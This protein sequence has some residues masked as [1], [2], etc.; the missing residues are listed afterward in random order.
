MTTRL[1]EPTIKPSG[2]PTYCS[3][4]GG[5]DPNKK[6]VDFDAAHDSGWYG[7]DPAIGIV[8]D[9]LFL[10]ETCLKTGAG[11]VGMVDGDELKAE[12]RS[13][14]EK[15]DAEERLRRQAQNYADRLEDAFDNRDAPIKVDHRKKPR[16]IR[17]NG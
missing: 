7:D 10:C 14:K 1:A 2:L 16:E 17:A 15:L 12:N 5:Q 13:L 8:K 9:D 4:C 3:C 6:H 11:F